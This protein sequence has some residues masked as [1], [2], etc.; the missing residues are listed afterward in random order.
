MCPR[1]DFWHQKTP[2]P[3]DAHQLN[4]HLTPLLVL[5]SWVSGDNRHHEIGAYANESFRYVSSLTQLVCIKV[6]HRVHGS[7]VEKTGMLISAGPVLFVFW[8]TSKCKQFVFFSF[9]SPKETSGLLRSYRVPLWERWAK[10]NGAIMEFVFEVPGSYDFS[11]QSQLLET[12][13]WA[14]RREENQGDGWSVRERE[15]FF[16]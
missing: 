13:Y 7:Q 14:L 11:L 10:S 1:G 8:R 6:E 12:V 15:F 16:F 2:H 3:P 9:L 4:P 5:N